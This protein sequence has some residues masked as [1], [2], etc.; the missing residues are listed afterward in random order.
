LKIPF[1][2]FLH[3]SMKQILKLVMVMMP[4][5]GY[6]QKQL[7]IKGDALLLSDGSVISICESYPKRISAASPVFTATVL[8]H[9]FQFSLKVAGGGLYYLKG[10]LRESRRF[11][12][13]EGAANIAIAD[14]AFKDIQVTENASSAEFDHYEDKV[15]GVA[16]FYEYSH[17]RADY[18]RY[19]HQYGTET[20]VAQ[21]KMRKRDSVLFELQN[22]LMDIG[23]VWIKQHPA[24]LINTYVLYDQ[25]TYMPETKLKEV[26][27]SIPFY[28]R[29]NIW[30]KELKYNIDSLFIGG[31]APDFA[32]ADTVGNNI[33]LTGFRGKYVLL[34]FWASWCIPCRNENPNIVAALV[35]FANRNFTILSVSVDHDRAAWLKAIKQDNLNWTHLSS[36]SGWKNAVSTKYGVLSIPSNFLIDPDGKIIA[37]NLNGAGLLTT[38]DTLLKN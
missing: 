15:E 16:L 29:S 28:T 35:K 34:D 18:D 38:L 19:I 13:S 17:A 23:L 5:L 36:L 7:S 32:Q 10:G 1:I 20:K 31:T 14:S 26:F 3:I 12:L 37:K 33:R 30:G 4:Y 22:Q 8:N 9:R 25:L 24:S 21:T 11:F 2:N 6:A 27:S